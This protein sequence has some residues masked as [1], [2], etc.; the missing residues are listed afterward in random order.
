MRSSA[1][2]SIDGPKGSGKTTLL[3]RL[4][5]IMPT[6]LKVTA[7]SEKDMDPFRNETEVLLE[8]HKGSMTRDVEQEI[9]RLLA[10]GR[11]AISKSV[12]P[13]AAADVVL[14]DRWYPSDAYFRRCV[15]FSDV[16]STNMA[17]GE[18]GR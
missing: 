4:T 9:V 13:N 2:I 17:E 16:L 11:A 10:A 1:F 14:M 3:R 8:N 18:I 12:L 15:P 5:E 6:S 7:F